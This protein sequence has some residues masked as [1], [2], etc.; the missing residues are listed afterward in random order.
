[1]E[2]RG[3]LSAAYV[4]VVFFNAIR[5]QVD[6]VSGLLADD[7]RSFG[8]FAGIRVQDFTVLYQ[9]CQLTLDDGHR[10]CHA[11]LAWTPWPLPKRPAAQ[12]PTPV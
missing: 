5:D 12:M 1:M 8:E 4:C 9:R 7:L 10:T 11:L 6:S 3:P 2:G